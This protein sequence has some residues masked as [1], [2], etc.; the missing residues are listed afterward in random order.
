MI[1]RV[2]CGLVEVIA[3]FSPTRAFIKVDFP[4]L[5]RPTRVTNP[6]RKSGVD[7]SEFGMG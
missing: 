1:R 6:Y 7:C 3:I 5:G 4:V 2:V